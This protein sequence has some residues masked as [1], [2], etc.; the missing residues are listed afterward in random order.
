MGGG[1]PEKLRAAYVAEIRRLERRVREAAP[2][3]R[4]A[5]RDAITDLETEFALEGWLVDD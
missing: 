1:L 4:E 3:D 2:E 5:L